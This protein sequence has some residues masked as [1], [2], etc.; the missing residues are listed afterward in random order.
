MN[1]IIEELNRMAGMWERQ[2]DSLDQVRMYFHSNHSLEEE[3]IALLNRSL[4]FKSCAQNIRAATNRIEEL[5]QTKQQH[6]IA[7]SEDSTQIAAQMGEVLSTKN[8][9][10]GQ[11][12]NFIREW[13]RKLMPC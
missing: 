3:R 8:L 2:A 5:L 11:Y 6:S 4:V 9:K 13:K 10:I 7:V 12:R 1:Y